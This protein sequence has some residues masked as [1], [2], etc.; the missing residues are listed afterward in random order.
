MSLPRTARRWAQ[1]CFVVS[2]AGLAVCAYLGFLHLSLLLGELYGG[3]ICGSIGT[4][5]NC[6]A[7]T[8]SPWGNFLGLP[9]ALWGVLG[10]LATLALSLIAWQFADWRSS[11]L[12]LVWA[13]G[14]ALVAIDIALLVVMVFQI[15]YLCALCL[16]TYGLNG[17]LVFGAHRGLGSG[18][19]KGFRAIPKALTEF[20]PKPGVAVAWIFWGILFTGALGVLAVDG[21]SRFMVEK[22]SRALRREMFRVVAHQ[23]RLVVDVGG[24]PVRGRAPSEV[25]VVEFSDFF[26]PVCR[27]AS[28]FDE[29]LAARHLEKIHFVF[30]HFPLDRACNKALQKTIHPGACAAA[31]AAECAH[32]QGRFWEFHHLAFRKGASGSR[33]GLEALAVDAG[34]DLEAFR[35]CMASG[36]GHE[37]VRRDV[38]EGERLGIA[39]T[40][41]YIVNG[42]KIPGA[43]PPT[44]FDELLRALRRAGRPSSVRDSPP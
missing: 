14:L 20:L 27:R 39:G 5:F 15:R 1:S 4:L 25:Q 43:M 32:E 42:V 44:L 19:G 3:G 28:A 8:L 23:P 13:G 10:Y 29:V 11:A 24:D 30:K 16:L 41:S 34:L 31:A 35:S 9:L 26:C 22:T 18:W 17:L 2:L 33:K 21:S 37:A 12:T 40:P 38:E 7:V 6:H 36:R